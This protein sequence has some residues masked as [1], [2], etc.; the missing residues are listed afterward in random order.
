[1]SNTLWVVYNLSS[2]GRVPRLLTAFP[3]QTWS[4]S[5]ACGSVHK[6][7]MHEN[8]VQQGL[9]SGSWVPGPTQHQLD[10]RPYYY[11]SAM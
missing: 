3:Q 1:M 10:M 2:L 11:A 6:Y 9:A 7:N 5:C 8:N 4:L